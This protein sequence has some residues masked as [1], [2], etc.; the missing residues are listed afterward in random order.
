MKIVK[1]LSSNFSKSVIYYKY[2]MY[3][4]IQLM[5]SSEKTS[6][7]QSNANFKFVSLEKHEIN[8]GQKLNFTYI[9]LLYFKYNVIAIMMH[10]YIF[11]TLWVYEIRNI[12]KWVK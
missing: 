2:T 11:Y 6:Q 8:T 12:I 10:K 5:I 1:N 4:S 7:K 9:L 3:L